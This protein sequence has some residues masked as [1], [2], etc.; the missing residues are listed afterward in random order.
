MGNGIR[1]KV[2]YHLKKSDREVELLLSIINY[3]S[4]RKCN[5]FV[6]N[7]P[8]QWKEQDLNNLFKPYGEIEKIYVSTNNYG[9]AFAF[10][11]FN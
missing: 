8:N 7:F 4:K 2:K 1:L 5:L 10:I 6:K 11:C 3:A 9:D